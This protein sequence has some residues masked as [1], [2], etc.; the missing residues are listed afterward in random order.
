MTLTNFCRRS[1]R[2]NQSISSESAIAR[3]QGSADASQH[4]IISTV[5]YGGF[6]A[7]YISSLLTRR[8]ADVT[9]ATRIR[10]GIDQIILGNPFADVG[11]DLRWRHN[12]SCVDQPPVYSAETCA[13]LDYAYPKTQAECQDSLLWADEHP[14]L[15]SR[16][17]A[18]EDCVEGAGGEVIANKYNR[19]EPP[20]STTSRVS[21]FCRHALAGKHK[22][23]GQKENGRTR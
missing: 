13:V 9:L 17:K 19:W 8:N 10:K 6:L 18:F 20:V 4:L 5:S 7:A 22:C 2:Q 15:D 14:G 21:P 1:T 3:V 23:S 16:T 11:A 12:S